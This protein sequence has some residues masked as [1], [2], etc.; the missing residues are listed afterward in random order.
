MKTKA[1][2]NNFLV[3]SILFF[4]TAGQAIGDWYWPPNSV[5]ILPQNPALSD[6]VNITLSGD[7]PDSCVPSSFPIEVDGNNIYFNVIS[8]TSGSCLQVVTPWQLTETAGPLSPGTYSVFVSLDRGPWTLMTE[9]DVTAYAEQ[10]ACV[11]IPAQSVLRLSGGF[12]GID[13]T[14]SIE[15]QFD[16]SVDFNAGTASF[17]QVDATLGSSVYLP[18][19]D[20]NELFRMTDMIGTVVSDT[21]IEF[22]TD[23]LPGG[24]TGDLLVTFQDRYVHLVGSFSE[25]FP[26]GFC[27]NLDAVA[28]KKFNT[29]NVSW[30]PGESSLPDWNIVPDSPTTCDLINFS[31]PTAIFGNS[32]SAEASMG[33]TPTVTIDPVNK[34]VELWF[35]PPPPDICPDVYLPVCG[36]EGSF[37]PLEAGE[38]VFSGAIPWP[39]QEDDTFWIPFQVAQCAPVPGDITGD[40]RVD[41]EDFAAFS[42]RWLDTGCG[43]CGGA[44]VTGDWDVEMDDLLEFVTYW[45]TGGGC[46]PGMSY[47]VDQCDMEVALE[48]EGDGSELRFSVTVEGDYIHFEDMINANCCKDEIELQMTVKGDLITIHEIEHTSSPCDCLCDYPTTATLGP[49]DEGEYLLEVIDVYGESLGVVSVVIGES[50]EAGLT[51]QID[52]CDLGMDQAGQSLGE[53]VETQEEELRFSVTVDGDYIH[54]EDMINANCCKDEIELQMTVKG[55]LITIH[56]IEHTSSPCLCLCDYPTT[57][58]LGPFDEG[59]YLLEVIDVYGESLGVVPV[60]IGE[61]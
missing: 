21:V 57:A 7:W 33:G 28:Q 43:A 55:D 58:T 3:T 50:G 39:G 23:S 31:G 15:G 44:D 45:L 25:P 6:V 12:A 20:L 22:E 29:K 10:N 34:T 32:C 60:T 47:Q 9:F 4:M 40:C 1:N 38:W 16:L 48:G 51:Y 56:E 8:D 37:G 26:D 41:L 13:E 35:Q 49:F 54:F 14:L 2:L 59:E 53:T 30:I 5:E 61:P 52:E 19:Q 24:I 27:F 36:L 18:T 46:E 42:G 17:D 11:F